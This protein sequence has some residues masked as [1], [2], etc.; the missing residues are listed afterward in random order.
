MKTAYR[1]LREYDDRTMQRDRLVD[2]LGLTM[3]EVYLSVPFDEC[4]N[5]EEG[6]KRVEC[7]KAEGAETC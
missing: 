7:L 3:V 4:A 2:F 5:V 6:S 1:D